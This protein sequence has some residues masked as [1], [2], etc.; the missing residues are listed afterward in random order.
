RMRTLTPTLAAA[1]SATGRQPLVQLKL[2]DDQEHYSLFRHDTPAKPV[3]G[4]AACVAPNG[5]LVRAALFDNGG[6]GNADLAVQAISN[7]NA[8]GQWTT[9]T[10]LVAASCEASQPLALSTNPGGVIRLF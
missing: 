9:W 10:T 5:N 7:P 3:D 1:I 8:A 4:C 6:A 2:A